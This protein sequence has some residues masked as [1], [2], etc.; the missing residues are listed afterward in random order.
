MLINVQKGAVGK[1]NAVPVADENIKLFEFRQLLVKRT[2]MSQD[3]KFQTLQG[4]IVDE[5]DEK[6][7]TLDSVLKKDD[8]TVTIMSSA[9]TAGEIDIT[10]KKGAAPAKVKKVRPDAKL[11]EFRTALADFMSADD[12]FL[13][14]EGE[15]EKSDEGSFTVK[16]VADKDSVTIKA[17]TPAITEKEI[18]LKKGEQSLAKRLSL[19]QKLSELRSA[20]KRGQLSFL[21]EAEQFLNRADAPIPINEEGSYTVKDVLRDDDSISIQPKTSGWQPGTTPTGV[22]TPS[23]STTKVDW[24][25]K[26]DTTTPD[27]LSDLNRNFATKSSTEAVKVYSLLEPATQRAIFRVLQLHRGLRIVPNLDKYGEMP[28]SFYN[29]IKV[30]PENGEVRYATFN[31]PLFDDVEKTASRELHEVAKKG[32]KA[33]EASAGAFGVAVTSKA[34]QSKESLSIRDQTKIYM[35]ARYRIPKVGLKL[36]PKD[37]SATDEFESEVRAAV[38]NTKSSFEQ[39]QDLFNLL[40]KYGHFILTE[41]TVGGQIVGETSKIVTTTQ[42]LESEATSF[43]VAFKA[44]VVTPKGKFEGGAG[45]S[46]EDDK[47]EKKVRNFSMGKITTHVWGGNP[48]TTGSVA[49]WVLSLNDPTSW[50]VIE[51]NELTPVI[52]YLKPDLRSKCVGLIRQ[53]ASSTWTQEKTLLDTNAYIQGLQLQDFRD[54]L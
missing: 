22:Q 4:S 35:L 25:L 18:K 29:A 10:V 42:E 50:A 27:L 38:M 31:M 2:L 9:P 23:L 5:S 41:C 26:G 32:V 7:V 33:G 45:Y 49:D 54:L 47:S 13:Y 24:A 39:Y 53:H 17:F 44:D 51:Y 6:D 30:I 12:R 43:G 37:I 52:A 48:A 28:K 21:S 36:D 16:D 20:L 34:S 1:K 46:Q 11:S 3:D 19:S 14:K 8:S 15:I 40:D